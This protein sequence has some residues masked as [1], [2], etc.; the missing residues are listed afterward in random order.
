VNSTSAI[1]I[2]TATLENELFKVDLLLSIPTGGCVPALKAQPT[3]LSMS[4][5]TLSGQIAFAA[6]QGGLVSFG[7]G[8]F[9]ILSD[10]K[11]CAVG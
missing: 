2:Q 6:P 8:I 9:P 5:S 11:G 7:L 4:H 1:T 3:N 10:G